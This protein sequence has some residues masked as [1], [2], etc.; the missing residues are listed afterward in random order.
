MTV[1]YRD[2]LRAGVTCPWGRP[3]WITMVVAT[4]ASTTRGVE[5]TSRKVVYDTASPLLEKRPQMQHL[6][7]LRQSSC[8]AVLIKLRLYPSHDHDE[9]IGVVIVLLAQ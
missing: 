3:S 2:Q 4:D 1:D 6:V 8:A 7:N 5:L 9:Y